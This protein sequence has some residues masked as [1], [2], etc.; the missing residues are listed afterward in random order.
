MIR[1]FLAIAMWC[2][3]LDERTLRS[4]SESFDIP[5]LV[6]LEEFVRTLSHVRRIMAYLQ[7]KQAGFSDK[8]AALFG[9]LF[10][11][12]DQND[13]RLIGRAELRKLMLALA[14]TEA[15][16]VSADPLQFG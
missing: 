8:E 3:K 4:V 6:A 16:E 14:V 7:R 10:R 2:C 12:Y 5:L 15:L 1:M 9:D 11:P 13:D